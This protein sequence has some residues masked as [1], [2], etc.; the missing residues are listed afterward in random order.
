MVCVNPD[1]SFNRQAM[2]VALPSL[3]WDS[4]TSGRGDFSGL[5]LGQTEEA[6]VRVNPRGRSKGLS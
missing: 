1:L 3:R 4:R 6:V 2:M 5:P